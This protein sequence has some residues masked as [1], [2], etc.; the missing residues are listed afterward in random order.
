MLRSP[1]PALLKIYRRSSLSLPFPLV[2]ALQANQ[3]KLQNASLQPSP[4]PISMILI[5]F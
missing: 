1:S 5:S 4:L 3:Q 2:I